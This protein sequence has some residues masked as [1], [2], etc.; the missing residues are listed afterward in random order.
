MLPVTWPGPTYWKLLSHRTDRNLR[1]PGS[2]AKAGKN[3]KPKEESAKLRTLRS[4]IRSSGPGPSGHA[5]MPA[6]AIR[7]VNP[8]HLHSLE[9]P[10]PAARHAGFCLQKGA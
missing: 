10:S 8:P 5:S 9:D 7:L 1:E 2:A 6:R 4:R 3:A